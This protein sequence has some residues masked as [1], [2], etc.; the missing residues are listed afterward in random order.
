MEQIDGQTRANC[1]YGVTTSPETSFIVPII[2]AG[3]F[4][5]W[6]AVWQG[7]LPEN[8]AELM[9]MIRPRQRK[10]STGEYLPE[11]Y[12]KI[13]LD[14]DLAEI[15]RSDPGAV[16]MVGNEPE[17]GPNPGE[18]YT[19]RTDDIHADIYAE[20]Y[21][22]IYH[23]IKGVDPT[24]RVANAGLIQ[25]TPMRL[26]YL[27]MMWDAYLQKY[28]VPMPVDVWTMHA[29]VLPELTQTGEP[30]NIA[31]AALGTDLALG[32][33]DSGRD[34]SKC[35]DPDVYCYAE[36]DDPSLLEEQ[37]VAMRQWM[38][39]R[40]QQ[41][42]PLV[43]TEYG[44]LYQYFIKEDGTCRI[45]DDNGEC[46]TPERVS[47]FMLETFDYFNHARD[48]NLGMTTDNNK[49]VQQ[50]I[51]YGAWNWD[52]ASADLLLNDLQTLSLMGETFRDHVY[53]E[54]RAVNLTI[55]GVTGTVKAQGGGTAT[56]Q[57]SASFRNN[58]NIAI[59]KPFTVTF[60]ED[61]ALTQAIGSTRVAPD[62][63]GCATKRYSAKLDW[64]GLSTGKHQFWAKIDS[65][66]VI[67]ESNESDNRGSGQVTVSGPVYALDVQI[68]SDGDGVGGTVSTT[69]AGLTYP[70][71]T[72][73]SLTA[74]PYTGW[75]FNGWKGAIKGNMPQATVTMVE[76]ISV[77]AHFEQDQYELL[78]KVIGEGKVTVTPQQEHF[79]Y[80]DE[81][82]ILAKPAAGWRFARWRGDVED[83]VPMIKY[84]FEG[85]GN[86]KAVF[87]ELLPYVSHNVF[88]PIS[89]GSSQE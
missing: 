44:T 62:I 34:A 41:D 84:T 24:A 46:F 7:P 20:A 58:G 9:H 23:F 51:W 72:V 12:S 27:D 61:A 43:V 35:A 6:S 77:E 59:Q 57:L 54:P 16:W 3:V 32:K 2:G 45:R 47:K 50:W 74:V 63:L 87:K 85:N 4:Y 89:M 80:G 11:W 40:D 70:K 78:L 73:V 31:S 49:L 66:N 42:K 21:H 81:V 55:D 71:E 17:R 22:D 75:A 19:P 53:A 37:V 10:T 64:E 8:G 29:Y 56:A 67:N 13:R 79:L 5:R 14:E 25:I 39:E 30:N 28:G 82:K 52:V 68:I 86:I 26:Q 83:G 36:H 33:R 69:P 18:T 60:Y 1:R 65:S 76:D 38:K 15:I 48:P 88:F